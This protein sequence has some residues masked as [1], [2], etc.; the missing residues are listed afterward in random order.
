MNL[1]LGLFCLLGGLL[2]S[3]P[4]LGAGHFAL[5]WLSGV[6]TLASLVPVLRFG[7]RHPAAQFA[8]VYLVLFLVGIVCTLSEAIAFFPETKVQ[9][10][11]DGLGGAVFDLIIAALLVGLARIFKLADPGTEQVPQRPAALAVP[12]VLAS[13][14]SYVVYYL[15]FGSIT[16]QFFTR[17]F[18]PHAQQQVAAMGVWFFWGYQLARGLVMTLAVLPVIYTLRLP[19]WQAA[20]VVGLMIWIVGGAAPLLVPNALMIPIQRYIHIVEI[21]SQNVSLG[22]TAVLLLRPRIPRTANSAAS[23]TVSHA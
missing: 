17:G 6:L 10:L 13:A 22:I 5:W 8:A 1:K 21:M 18:Y 20:L 15:I 4:A 19:R 9:M 16:Y 2:F 11:H 3:F 12:L 14:A 7:P 23:Q